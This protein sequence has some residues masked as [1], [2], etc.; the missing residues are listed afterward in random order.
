MSEPSELYTIL[1]RVINSEMRI[2]QKLNRVANQLTSLDQSLASLR[3]RVLAL[4][5]Y[6]DTDE[7]SR[8]LDRTVH[9]VSHYGSYDEHLHTR[10]AHVPLEESV[11]TALPSIRPSIHDPDAGDSARNVLNVI[12]NTNISFLFDSGDACSICLSPLTGAVRTTRLC[13]HSFHA[14]CL[15]TWAATNPSCPLCRST[16]DRQI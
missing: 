12:L 11:S 14:N 2:I 1:E 8:D 4:E 15:E 9:E 6:N 10:D 3:S 16:F 5:L 13:N 7:F